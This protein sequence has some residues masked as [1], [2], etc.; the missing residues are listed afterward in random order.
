MA[1]MAAEYIRKADKWTTMASA[2][3]KRL[4]RNNWIAWQWWR[5]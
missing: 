3:D 1:E 2:S 4:L 5:S